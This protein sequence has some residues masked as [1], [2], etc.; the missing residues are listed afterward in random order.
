MW[1]LKK[2][3]SQATIDELRALRNI[4]EAKRSTPSSICDAL[5]YYSQGFFDYHFAVQVSYRDIV[6]QVADELKIHCK[7]NTPTK[8]VEIHIAQKLMKTI[9][10]KM[11]RKE[12]QLFEEEWEKIS[13]KFS[14]TPG[15]IKS[16]GIF[17]ALTAA[18]ISGFGVYL[19]ATTTLGAITSGLGITLP[20]AAYIGLSKAISVIIGPAGWLWAIFFTTWSLNSP[21]YEKV[22]PA[23]LYISALRYEIN[24]RK[25]SL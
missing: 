17:A 15:L 10:K 22:I 21:N 2:L 14:K 13:N 6:F 9:W 1:H 20:F 18:Q 19:L 24:M 3:L 12:R 25:K 7:E 5:R 8:K 23:I 11:T 4:L 16:G